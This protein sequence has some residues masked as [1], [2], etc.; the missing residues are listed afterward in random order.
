MRIV[1]RTA[2][3]LALVASSGLASS[4]CPVNYVG[5]TTTSHCD[6]I[7]RVYIYFCNNSPP[8][9]VQV[10]DCVASS[11]RLRR[12]CFNTVARGVSFCA[13]YSSSWTT[14][15][16]TSAQTTSSTTQSSISPATPGP[17]GTDYS[18]TDK[19]PPPPKPSVLPE[20][21]TSPRYAIVRILPDIIG[22]EAPK[23]VGYVTFTQK[24]PS[25]PVSISANVVG[26][27]PGMH[28]WHVHKTGNIYPNC[29]AAGPHFNPHKL[30][31]GGPTAKIRH[32]G[33]FGN[34]EATEE[35]TFVSTIIDHVATLYG[36]NSI[37]S[38]ALVLHEGVDDLGLTENPAS[39]TT[40]NSGARLACG[41]IGYM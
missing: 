28:G 40:G 41:V 31:H 8:Q 19:K 17:D 21:D 34:F 14:S 15:T 3:S 29:S 37:L 38:R 20:E 1:L 10:S 11:N 22:P 12:S 30:D 18:L 7:W 5:L 24:S 9:N 27:P 16:S 6:W 2:I 39:K 26:I 4:T 36:P 32:A 25:D 33:D 23:I 13:Y 35:G